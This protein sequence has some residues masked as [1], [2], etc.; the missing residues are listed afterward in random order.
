MLKSKKKV[1]RSAKKT[2]GELVSRPHFGSSWWPFWIMQ[3]V[4]SVA[5]S[6][7][8]LPT[9]LGW[10]L[11]FFS[12]AFSLQTV[13]LPQ[14]K[15]QCCYCIRWFI[16]FVVW[17]VSQGWTTDN[18]VLVRARVKRFAKFILGIFFATFGFLIMA[19]HSV[20]PSILLH[21]WKVGFKWRA[22]A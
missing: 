12:S 15:V 19:L 3:V 2:R 10:Y 21:S 14:C 22:G 9:P 20:G 1:D 11:L 13:K 6:E 4:H 16:V 17:G 8:V 18:I 7:R 5:A